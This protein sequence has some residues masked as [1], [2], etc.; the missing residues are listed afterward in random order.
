MNTEKDQPAPALSGDWIEELAAKIAGTYALIP[1]AEKD[2]AEIIRKHAPRSETV[3]SADWCPSCERPYTTCYCHDQGEE[4]VPSVPATVGGEWE[5]AFEAFKKV[6][7]GTPRSALTGGGWDR[8]VRMWDDFE[9][10]IAHLK[11]SEVLPSTQSLPPSPEAHRL[12][13]ETKVEYELE[14]RIGDSWVLDIHDSLTANG[15]GCYAA[16][17]AARQRSEAFL[18]TLNLWKET[19]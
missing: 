10:I 8:S 5:S 12:E 13:G 18:R 16:H 17:A 4:P 6:S 15:P 11:K 9:K 1:T 14:T 19:K 2:I 7:T 3:P